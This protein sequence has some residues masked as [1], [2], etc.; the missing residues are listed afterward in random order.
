MTKNVRNC[1]PFLVKV[2]CGQFS[3]PP[4]TL[5]ELNVQ[6]FTFLQMAFTH[7][8][9]VRSKQYHR[10][11]LLLPSNTLP[12]GKKERGRML[13]GP[14]LLQR[15]FWIL[16]QDSRFW[17]KEKFHLIENCCSTLHNTIVEDERHELSEQEKDDQWACDT[18]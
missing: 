11:V 4:Y 1:S 8:C 16:A 15:R 10:L 9:P 5:T 14:L 2:I 6:M 17:L 18:A 7:N 12:K 3:I 13:R